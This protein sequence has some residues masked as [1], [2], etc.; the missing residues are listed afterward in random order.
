VLAEDAA[1]DVLANKRHRREADEAENPL[2]AYRAEELARML[3]QDREV[4]NSLDPRAPSQPRHECWSE[5]GTRITS[6]SK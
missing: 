6:R 4:T 1:L 5:V 3:N 2:A